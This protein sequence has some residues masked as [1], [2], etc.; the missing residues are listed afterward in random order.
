MA[1][2]YLI[3]KVRSRQGVDLRSLNLGNISC[4]RRVQ[5]TSAVSA[6]VGKTKH[7]EKVSTTVRIYL[8][9]LGGM[10]VKSVSPLLDDYPKTGVG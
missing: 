4:M 6:L 2:R 9:F 10:C 8:F 1:G 7:P 5:T 3:L